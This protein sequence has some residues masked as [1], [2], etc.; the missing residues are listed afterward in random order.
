MFLWLEI[1][2]LT[3]EMGQRCLCVWSSGGDDEVGGRRVSR[4]VVGICFAL[5]M[6]LLIVAPRSA[7]DNAHWRVVSHAPFLC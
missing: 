5:S 4:V 3:C 7:D 1:V 6:A 2:V